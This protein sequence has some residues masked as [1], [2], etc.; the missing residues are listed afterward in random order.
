MKRENDELRQKVKDLEAHV[1]KITSSPVH[2]P[3]RRASLPDLIVLQ[4]AFAAMDLFRLTPHRVI[5]EMLPYTNSRLEYE[6]MMSYSNSYPILAP[7]DVATVERLPQMM[8]EALLDDD[9]SSMYVSTHY[10]FYQRAGHS[11]I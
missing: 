6:L 4:D 2:T 10:A 9:K 8:T 1:Y 3:R 5:R 7:L 11:H